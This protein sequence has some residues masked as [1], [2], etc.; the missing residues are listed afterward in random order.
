MM[1]LNQL[2]LGYC[3]FLCLP[4]VAC[5]VGWVG[6]HV[7]GLLRWWIII[8]G[9]E[10]RIKQPQHTK[11]LKAKQVL[12]REISDFWRDYRCAVWDLLCFRPDPRLMMLQSQRCLIEFW[13]V[14][15]SS[16]N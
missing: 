16:Y 3:L 13:I 15:T 6:P 8:K 7:A 2:V 5:Y 11:S 10:R 14:E 12:E 9:Y 4:I 1:T